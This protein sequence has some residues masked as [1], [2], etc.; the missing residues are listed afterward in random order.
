ME[1]Y[2]FCGV[3]E[4]YARKTAISVCRY[5]HARLSPSLRRHCRESDRATDDFR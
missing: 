3:Q 5:S 2:L 4:E 1:Y